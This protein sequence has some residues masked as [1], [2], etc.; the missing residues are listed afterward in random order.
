MRSLRP[1]PSMLV[2]LLA[3]VVAM[4]GTAIAAGHHGT[5]KP[6]HHSDASK[7][8]KLIRSLAPTL[9]VAA[10]KRADSATHATGA[11]Q[12]ATAT[13]AAQLGGLA[14]S[15]YQGAVRWALVNGNSIVEQSG[16]I[17]ISSFVT[18]QTILNFGSSVAGHALMSTPVWRYSDSDA[19]IEVQRC[20]GT[21]SSAGDTQCSAPGTNDANHVL[22]ATF[23]TTGGSV[24]AAA[25]EYYIAS[26]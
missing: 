16:G 12:A 8:K 7:D 20:G 25:E 17:S 13:N 15:A 2:A 26:L 9:S 22:V 23:G 14:P 1:S 11:D 4:G 21:S 5:K 19:T 3:L 10:A 6:T 24:F 18:G